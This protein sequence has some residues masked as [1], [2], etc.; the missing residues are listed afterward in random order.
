MTTRIVASLPE[1]A[2]ADILVNTFTENN[3]SAQQLENTKRR[4]RPPGITEAGL[5]AREL[6]FR[7]AV[8][9]MIEVGYDATTL[10][11]VAR[12][13][14]V[15]A[16]LL[17]RHYPGKRALV[18]ELYQRLSAEY[19]AAASAMPRAGWGERFLFALD[20]S[21]A[22]LAPHRSALAA[23]LPVLVSDAEGGLFSPGGE[24][25][26]RSVEVVFEEAVT[27]ARNAPGTRE[28][29]AAL[30]RVLYLAHLGV[31]LFW[32]LDRSPDQ[33]ATTAVRAMLSRALPI[34]T[35]ALRIGRARTLVRELDAAARLAFFAAD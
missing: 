14:G 6:L 5:R 35:F 12:R 19:A 30:G 22:V 27:G 13:A 32:L 24:P 4:G 18:L 9:R 8:E 2:G 33:A 1:T 20:T 29:A 11:D 3:M 26:R 31:L 34:V 15:S 17:Y 25:C 7:T 21:L 10:R 28:E 16:A 23:L